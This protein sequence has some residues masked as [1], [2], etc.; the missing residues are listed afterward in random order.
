MKQADYNI[1]GSINNRLIV[2]KKYTYILSWTVLSIS[3][4]YLFLPPI[5]ICEPAVRSGCVRSKFYTT[6]V[7]PYS[8]EHL[9]TV[10]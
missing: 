4:F 6:K 9:S 3:Y 2:V 8:D 1:I 5:C 10:P 7:F